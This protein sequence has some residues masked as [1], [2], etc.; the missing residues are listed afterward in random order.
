MSKRILQVVFVLAMIFCCVWFNIGS[1]SEDVGMQEITSEDVVSVASDYL[2][3]NTKEEYSK[4][5]GECINYLT[6]LD[7]TVCSDQS[8]ISVSGDTFVDGENTS[9]GDIVYSTEP[10]YMQNKIL[11]R[12]IGS[13]GDVF[14]LVSDIYGETVDISNITKLRSLY[15]FDDIFVSDVSSI[16]SQLV[17]FG[18]RADGFDNYFTCGDLFTTV[19]VEEPV[20]IVFAEYAKSDLE[21]KDCD[22]LV[23]Q[24]KVKDDLLTFLLKLDSHMKIYDID[25]I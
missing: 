22:M 21:L 19:G 3:A 7:I 23:M 13:S 2:I 1:S 15:E 8:N 11:M 14:T 4:M 5:A 12:F 25:L 17:G 16:L 24:V 20:S 18:V 10:L 9:T 6:Y